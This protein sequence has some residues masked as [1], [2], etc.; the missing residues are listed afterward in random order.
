MFHDYIQ[1]I[2]SIKV[3]GG[4]YSSNFD[5]IGVVE[6][7]QNTDLPQKSLAVDQIIEDMRHL[8]NGNSFSSGTVPGL[9]DHAVRPRAD[10]SDDLVVRSDVPVNLMS[11]NRQLFHS[12]HIYIIKLN[13]EKLDMLY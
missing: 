13:R 5:Y 3:L 12:G 11:W 6:I 10:L 1:F 4:N 2:E 8:L 7:S 9:T